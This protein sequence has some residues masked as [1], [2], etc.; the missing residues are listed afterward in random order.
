MRR[1]LVDS[2]VI[3]SLPLPFVNT[4]CEVFSVFFIFFRFFLYPRI[5]PL[6]IHH[7]T[8]MLTIFIRTI[9]LYFTLIVTMRFMGK[10][11]IGEVQ[12]SEFIITIM[13]SEIAATPILDQ[14]VP[15]LHAIAAIVLLLSVE[16]LVSYLLIKSSRLKHLICGTPSILIRRGELIQKELKKNRVDVE[17]LFS[18]LRQKGYAA[19]SDINYAILEE[20]GQLSV[21][22]YTEKAPATA[23]DLSL[24]PDETGIDHLCVADGKILEDSL[25]IIG[26]TKEQL[27]MEIRKRNLRLADIFILTI[28]DKNNLRIIPKML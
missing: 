2:P 4:F 3:I 16:L 11:Q 9:I 10:R 27:E 18:E 28:D 8:S 14:S 24:T 21:F 7:T 15:L 20:N 25:R 5:N 6:K 17:E 22:P 1:R 23:H 13:L 12:I 26:W 19:L